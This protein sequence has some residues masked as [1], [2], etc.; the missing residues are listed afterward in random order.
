MQVFSSMTC[1]ASVLR[2]RREP[3]SKLGRPCHLPAG[4]GGVELA[5]TIRRDL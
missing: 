1:I 4:D 2:G 3:G 5:L